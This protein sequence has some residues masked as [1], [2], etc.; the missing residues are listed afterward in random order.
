MDVLCLRGVVD[1]L[2][3]IKVMC[4]MELH[5]R[6]MCVMDV[7]HLMDVMCVM[8]VTCVMESHWCDVCD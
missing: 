5:G 7:L 8:D 2:C 3:S 6:V 1:V 4:V